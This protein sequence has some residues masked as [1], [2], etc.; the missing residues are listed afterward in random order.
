MWMEL[1][2]LRDEIRVVENMICGQPMMPENY[3]PEG[4]A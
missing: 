1:K 3:I 2:D 4:L